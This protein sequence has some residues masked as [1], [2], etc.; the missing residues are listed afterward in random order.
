MTEQPKEGTPEHAQRHPEL[1]PRFAD[2]YQAC[3]ACGALLHPM[4]AKMHAEHC[5]AFHVAL[6]A[7]IR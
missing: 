1:W 5:Y 3:P 2:G 7:Q 6:G 4:Y